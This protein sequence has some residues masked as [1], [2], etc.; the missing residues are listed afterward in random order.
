MNLAQGAKEESLALLPSNG[1]KGGSRE[2]PNILVIGPGGGARRLMGRL[3]G[4]GFHVSW[5]PSARHGLQVLQ[6]K[7]VS[8]ALIELEMPDMDGFTVLQLLRANV[9]LP[10]PVIILSSAHSGESI[11]QSLRL[12]ARDFVVYPIDYPILLRKIQRL[13]RD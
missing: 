12:G 5:A 4:E 6:E 7:T 11:M 3:S 1:G 10:P 9:S 8:L 13:T 2:V